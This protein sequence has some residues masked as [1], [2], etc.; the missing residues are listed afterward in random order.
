MQEPEDDWQTPR[1]SPYR[2]A[3]HL[4]SAFAIYSGLVWTALDIV[5]PRPLLLSSS[6]SEAAV[7]ASQSIRSK[8]LL[9]L[10]AL[11]AVTATS[12]AFVAG[13]D[14]G[15]AYNTFPLMGGRLVPEEYWSDRLP[16]LRNLFENTAAVQ[17]RSL[18]RVF[19]TYIRSPT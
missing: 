12:G 15:R 8:M 16:W 11:V 1:V 4:V 7:A 17:V 2:L 19:L 10:A 6:A 3:A 5:T 18:P 13:M 14:A 9:P